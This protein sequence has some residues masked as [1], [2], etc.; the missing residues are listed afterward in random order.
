MAVIVEKPNP[1]PQNCARLCAGLHISSAGSEP[2]ASSPS[3]PT[4]SSDSPPP[5]LWP[6][7]PCC[8]QTESPQRRVH[9][10][11]IMP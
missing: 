2:F 1:L 8:P 4:E 5:S 9:R 3:L 11:L 10:I 6:P 7:G